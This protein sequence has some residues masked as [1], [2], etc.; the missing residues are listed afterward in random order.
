MEKIPIS[1]LR[2]RMLRDRGLQ[3][4]TR[5]PKRKR[6]VD[7]I[8]AIDVDTNGKTKHMQYLELKY[9]VRIEEVLLSGTLEEV[10][11]RLGGEVNYSTISR[12]IKRLKLRYS[13][14]N[15]PSC[16]FCLHYAEMYCPEGVCN[17][18][19][20][21]DRRDLLTAKM[22]QMEQEVADAP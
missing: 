6:K 7:N 12:W 9:G 16:E 18:L 22:K 13:E 17:L 19:L 10:V 14:E 21:L 20:K 3:H 15:L 11:K 4:I 1:Q 5:D 8:P 2:K